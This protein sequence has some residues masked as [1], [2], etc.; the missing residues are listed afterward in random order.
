MR[1]GEGFEDDA[2]LDRDFGPVF[3]RRPARAIIGK[4]LND[5]RRAI[6]RRRGERVRYDVSDDDDSDDNAAAFAWAREPVR[7]N[8][9]TKAIAQKWLQLARYQASKRPGTLKG[10]RRSGF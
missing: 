1:L 8:A 9:S 10:R 4:W 3:L 2:G 7:A 6:A 5:A